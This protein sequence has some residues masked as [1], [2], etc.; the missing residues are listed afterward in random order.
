MTGCNTTAA[1]AIACSLLFIGFESHAQL[2]ASTPEPQKVVVQGEKLEFSG[3]RE[4]VAGKII[5]GREWLERAAASTIAEALRREASVS[6][7]TN[8]KISLK[9]LPGYTQILLDGQ[10]ITIGGDPLQMEPSLI[11]RVEIIHSASA[12]SGAFGLAGTINVVTRNRRKALPKQFN[13]NM[14]TSGLGGKGGVSLQEGW[15]E[16]SGTIFNIS[17]QANK[18]LATQHGDTTWT[19]AN[20]N[21][22]T[23]ANTESTEVRSLNQSVSVTPSLTWKPTTLDELQLTGNIG[24]SKLGQDD[25]TALTSGA[26]FADGGIRPYSTNFAD[27]TKVAYASVRSQWRHKLADGGNWSA[28]IDLSQEQKKQNRDA[29][30]VW[31]PNLPNQFGMT[32]DSVKHFLNGRWQLALPNRAGHKVQFSLSSNLSTQ[33]ADH[34]TVV[35][36][37]LA[38]GDQLGSYQ[39]QLRSWNS[40]AWVQDDWKVSGTLDMKWGWRQERRIARWE[41]GEIQSRVAANLAAPSLNV[42]WKLDPDGNQTITLGVARSFSTIGPAMLNP[43]PDI[44]GTSLCTKTGGCGANDATK[45]DRVG[46]PAL[47]YENGWGLDVALESQWRK[48]SQ[49]SV[50]AYHRWINDTFAWV[51][52]RE[53]VPWA[54]VP[55]W[56]YRPRNVG[57][58][59]AFGL[60]FGVDTELS[61]WME[62][63]PDLGINVSVQWNQSR[64]S[65]LP[66]PDN[67]LEGQQ[68]WS[69]RI[70]LTY[71]LNDK[72]V[73][74]QADLLFN[75]ANWWQAS[76]D[77]RIYS[78]TYRAI[79]AKAIWTFSPQYKFVFSLQDLLP[80]K[81][82]KLT[83]FAGEP[84]VQMSSRHPSR[85][86]F[87][88]RIE[89]RFE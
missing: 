31:S 55:R 54:T 34:D 53:T 68:P 78:D 51:T 46:N 30:T 69:S 76:V 38:T 5:L 81:N 12:D 16:P 75:P 27:W 7:G 80:A 57:N 26:P 66:G 21:G 33:T 19:S 25:G 62:K 60:T 14:G 48:E 84:M 28:S 52:Q 1:A 50:R 73:E 83:Q 37:I 22:S 85:T 71:K 70:G 39:A 58:A 17:L 47:K 40:A 41:S 35:N 29:N 23:V 82:G 74:L 63:A 18:T 42:A 64:L 79:S 36:G 65:T 6:V 2:P 8:G 20:N 43:R 49:W 87:A 15:R 32:E 61:D 67:R 86:L 13:L 59:T 10:P 88:V 45:P 3:A 9:G 11:D 4:V 56:V 89:S 72:P 24:S 44:T 77:R